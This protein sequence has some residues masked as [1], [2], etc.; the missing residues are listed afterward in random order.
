ME[1]GEEGFAEV[2][3]DNLRRVADGGEVHARVPAQQQVEIGGKL[4]APSFVEDGAA[5]IGRKQRGQTFG[6]HSFSFG[7]SFGKS[8][9]NHD[10]RLTIP[11]ICQTRADVGHTLHTLS[12]AGGGAVTHIA[13]AVSLH[14][15]EA[16]FHGGRGRAG[17]ARSARGM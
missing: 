6:L 10:G 17:A 7:F 2:A 3:G 16:C 11:N 13:L 15:V 12:L 5:E 1:C 4:R 9:C 8:N 14:A